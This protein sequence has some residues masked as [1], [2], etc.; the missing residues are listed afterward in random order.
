MKPRI[1]PSGVFIKETYALLNTRAAGS[2]LINFGGVNTEI[3]IPIL[4][5]DINVDKSFWYYQGG[6]V[7]DD[8]GAFVNVSNEKLVLDINNSIRIRAAG[9]G[10]WVFK[11]YKNGVENPGTLITLETPATP[12]SFDVSASRNTRVELEPEDKL[13]LYGATTV[14]PFLDCS[15][16]MLSIRAVEIYS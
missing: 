16:P 11:L 15:M 12:L 14:A 6:L 13:E 8:T 3:K 2:A 9:A 10:T 5:G 4:I 7:L 1:S